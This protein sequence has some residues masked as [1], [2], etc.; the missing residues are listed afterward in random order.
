MNHCTFGKSRLTVRSWVKDELNLLVSTVNREKV[1]S[2]R[3]PVTNKN[4]HE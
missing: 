2:R 1:S 3:L 4:A